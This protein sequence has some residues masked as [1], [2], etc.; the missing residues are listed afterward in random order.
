MALVIDSRVYVPTPNGDREIQL[1]IGDITALPIED[2]A[3]VLCIS[4]FPGNHFCRLVLCFAD[5]P[6][7]TMTYL[8]CAS[9]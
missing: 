3:D 5:L 1:C 7:C 6:Q 2:K 9:T 4:C 8:T